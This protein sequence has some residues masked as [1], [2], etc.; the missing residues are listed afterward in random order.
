[1]Q[2]KKATKIHANRKIKDESYMTSH[3]ALWMKSEGEMLFL[4][5]T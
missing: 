5:N 4:G 2:G 1:M 3:D